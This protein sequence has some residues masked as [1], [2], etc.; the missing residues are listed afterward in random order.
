[1][2]KF[3][4]TFVNVGGTYLTG[5]NSAPPGPVI[6]VGYG[7]WLSIVCESFGP[8]HD[9]STLS[10]SIKNLNTNITNLAGNTNGSDG[11]N[12]IS[13]NELTSMKSSAGYN[14]VFNQAFYSR[15]GNLIYLHNNI[16]SP[17]NSPYYCSFDVKADYNSQTSEDLYFYI[18]LDYINYS[19]EEELISCNQYPLP[20]A[21]PPVNSMPF[22]EWVHVEIHS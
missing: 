10:L 22:N 8:F 1:M 16:S 7:Q 21:Y 9:T 11:Y 5:W 20:M 14:K 2:L 19:N 17:D 15:T 3:G 4:N 12:D 13:S 18:L 6:P